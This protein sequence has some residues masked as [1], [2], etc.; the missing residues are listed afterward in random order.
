MRLGQQQQ[1]LMPRLL[2]ETVT[3]EHLATPWWARLRIRNVQPVKKSV[4]ARRIFQNSCSSPLF[5]LRSFAVDR[6]QKPAEDLISCL[7]FKIVKKKVYLPRGRGLRK[8][9]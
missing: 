8:G 7:K 6:L 1:A 4:V 3:L 9:A 5:L 2:Q